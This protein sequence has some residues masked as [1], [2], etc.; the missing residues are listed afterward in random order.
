MSELLEKYINE[1]KDEW[2]AQGK[3]D[4]LAEVREEGAAKEA[5]EIAMRMIKRGR[6]LMMR[7]LK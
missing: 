3:A 7:L 5:K 6:F 1:H 2:C 4:G